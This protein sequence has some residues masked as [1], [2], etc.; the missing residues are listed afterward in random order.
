M[1]LRPGLRLFSVACDTELIVVKAPADPV[2]VRIGGHPASISA[3]DLEGRV[4]VL[5]PT[6]SA[7]KVGKRYVDTTAT[8]EFLCT[9]A[10]A[11]TIAIG[12]LACLVKDAKQMPASD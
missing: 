5:T 4:R 11:G 9:R 3:P 7:A 1:Q 10:G 6:E 2:D 12:E 8:L